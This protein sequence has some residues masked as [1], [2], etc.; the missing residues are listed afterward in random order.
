MW[1]DSSDNRIPAAHWAGG[2]NSS[3][4]KFP[5]DSRPRYGFAAALRS[6][7]AIQV[8]VV[9]KESIVDGVEVF[10]GFDIIGSS[11]N[12]VWFRGGEILLRDA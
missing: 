6:A 4:T 10:T 9:F 12:P 5:I 1:D 3:A 11:E 7:G 2:G 8:L